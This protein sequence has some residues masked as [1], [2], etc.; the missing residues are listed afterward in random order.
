MLQ[1]PG[2]ALAMADAGRRTVETDFTVDGMVEKT[3][4]IYEEVMGEGGSA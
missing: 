3:I 1:D 2:T 4:A